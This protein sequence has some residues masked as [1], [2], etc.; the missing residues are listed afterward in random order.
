MQTLLARGHFAVLFGLFNLPT[1]DKPYGVC[2]AKWP[3]LTA[4]DRGPLW[5]F[6]LA[7]LTTY[8]DEIVAVGNIPSL[9]LIEGHEQPFT[10]V[11]LT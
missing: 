1:M 8:E 6:Y 9:G 2:S 5:N 10:C 7:E 3:R 11:K 4:G